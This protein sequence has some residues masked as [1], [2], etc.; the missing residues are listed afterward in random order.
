MRNFYHVLFFVRDLEQ[1]AAVRIVE[2]AVVAPAR[3]TAEPDGSSEASD[4]ASVGSD[5]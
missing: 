2:Q 3:A 5:F 1:L 4:P